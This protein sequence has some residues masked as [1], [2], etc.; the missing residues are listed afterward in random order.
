MVV[1]RHDLRD[2]LSRLC[3]LL[4]TERKHRAGMNNV[5]HKKAAAAGA[6]PEIK[7]PRPPD[8]FRP[9]KQREDGL[10]GKREKEL[11]QR[12]PPIPM[13]PVSLPARDHVQHRTKPCNLKK[14]KACSRGLKRCIRRASTFRS[15][16]CIAFSPRWKP[17]SADPAGYSVA[18]TN[19]KG[20][21]VAFLKAILEAAGYRARVHLTP[22][23]P[24]PRAH[25]AR[26]T[27]RS[28]RHRRA[29]SCRY[30]EPR[31][32]RQPREP[33]TFLRSPPRRLSWRLLKSG[34]RGAS[35]NRSRRQAR[36]NERDG[37]A[38]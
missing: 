9:G 26:G 18:G 22:F 30:F 28:A 27:R 11:R 32:S 3:S 1:H 23:A 10:R 7:V 14:Q 13:S 6:S 16:A 4:V 38:S 21:V 5:K 15:A 2:T 25:H 20:S 12:P 8:N 33:I 36:C 17:A 34:G 29:A 31:R 37:W 19:G 35:R 24:V